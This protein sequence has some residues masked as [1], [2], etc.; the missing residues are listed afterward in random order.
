MN[1][2]VRWEKQAS[3]DLIL[4]VTVTVAHI[5]A[6][7]VHTRSLV[8]QELEI[9]AK[10]F[11]PTFEQALVLIDSDAVN[12]TIEAVRIDH[13]SQ[14]DALAAVARDLQFGWILRM[15]RTVSGETSR[16]G[17]TCKKK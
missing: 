6:E 2:Y 11:R 1:E 16:Q 12:R 10:T 13:P 4:A 3:F 5:A 15:I 7:Y 17:E 14:A 8:L 9:L